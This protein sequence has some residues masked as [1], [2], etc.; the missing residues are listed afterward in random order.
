M[1]RQ[2]LNS[3]DIILT[4]KS[5]NKLKSQ[6]SQ[7][8]VSAAVAMHVDGGKPHGMNEANGQRFGRR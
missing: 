7:P 4:L 2:C 8:D 6:F 3:M 1:S 5:I